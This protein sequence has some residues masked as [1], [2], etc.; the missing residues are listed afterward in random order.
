MKHLSEETLLLALEGAEDGEA[1]AHLAECGLCRGLLDEAR[2]GEEMARSSRTIPEPSPLYWEAFR[3]N[4]DERIAGERRSVFRPAILLPA[5]A[6]AAVLV[7]AIGVLGVR[8]P[9]PTPAPTEAHLAAWTALPPAD[10]DSGL[11]LIQALGPSPDEIVPAAG[12]ETTS[13]CVIDRLS[14]EESHSFL[15][16]MRAE[17]GGS[18]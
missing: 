3:R 7:A 13:E 18:L 12:C 5:L 10:D 15:E 6:A 2:Q 17:K 14:E 4:L 1:R 16:R 9:R 11:A 8:T